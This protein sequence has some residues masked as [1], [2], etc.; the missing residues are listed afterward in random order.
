MEAEIVWLPTDSLRFD[1]NIG[2]MDSEITQGGDSID[3]GTPL[4]Y[5]PDYQYNIGAEYAV[6]LAAGSEL[7]FRLDFAGVDDFFSNAARNQFYILD[8]YETLDVNVSYT[9]ASEK[10]T[11]S[12]FGKNLT[13]EDYFTQALSFV[14][15]APFGVIAGT[16][17]RGSQYGVKFE[18]F[19]GG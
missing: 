14:N 16:P 1:A 13:D 2:F 8:G 17:A 5:T 19:F 10:W 9:A 15:D 7:A 11:A 3:N 12:V 18:Y 4:P 6:P